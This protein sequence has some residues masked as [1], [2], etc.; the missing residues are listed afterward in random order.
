MTTGSY[1][2]L[3]QCVQDSVGSK[4]IPKDVVCDFESALIGAIRT[5]S[6]MSQAWRCKLKRYGLSNQ[7]AKVAMSPN[8]FD[9]LTV[10]D[11]AKSLYREL[12]G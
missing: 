8:V 7:E 10:I 6:R 9:I 4:L 12:H 2:K 11:P 5:F 3:L 1:L